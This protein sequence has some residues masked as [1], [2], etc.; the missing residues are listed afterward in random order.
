MTKIRFLHR[1]EIREIHDPD[2]NLTVLRWLRENEGLTG[3]KEGCAEGDCGACTVVLGSLD[4]EDQLI[5]R[6][7][8]SCI[9]LLPVLDGKQL[10][11]IEDIGTPDDLHPVQDAMVASHGSQCGFCTPGF[12]ASLFAE[13]HAE[14]PATDQRA[15]AQS[16]AGN[17]CRCT[18]YRPIL[19]AGLAALKTAGKDKFQARRADTISQLKAIERAGTLTT[20]YGGRSYSAPQTIEDLAALFEA[21]PDAKL[22]AGGTDIGL[23]ITKGRRSLDTIIYTGMVRDLTEV[24]TNETAIT[25]GAAAPYTDAVPALTKDFP[26]ASELFSRLG[27]VQVRNL[28]TLGGNIANASPIGD[29][30]PVLI[31]LSADLVLRQGKNE[32]QI[33]IETFFTDYRQTVLRPGEFIA[34]IIVPRRNQANLY[35]FYKLTKRFDQDISAVCGG[36]CLTV[37]DDVVTEARL[38]FGGMAATP[39]RGHTAEKMLIGQPWN[40]ASAD[41][42]A[43][44]L[45]DD[46]TPLSDFRASA[47]YRRLSAQNLLRRFWLD[48]D[49]ARDAQPTGVLD[50]V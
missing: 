10:I 30:P 9:L 17:L 50:Y 27:A 29:T 2:P 31:A 44:A 36:F 8:N 46:F 37:R 13:Y 34:R 1:G 45:G 32:R 22:L 19:D 3:T 4:A 47:D 12:V 42:A 40:G 25:I 16:L 39:K 14:A 43:T 35:G 33:A 7:V 18:G 23:E 38:A 20:N 28:G 41:L 15:L 26:E 24:T 6:A 48:T 49:P 5:Y 11:A 21:S